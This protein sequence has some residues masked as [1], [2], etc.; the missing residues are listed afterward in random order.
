MRIILVF[1]FSILLI[2]LQLTLA[3]RLAVFGVTPNL[4]L[5]AVLSWAVWRQENK[6][7]WLILIPILI[8]DLLAGRPFGLVA[9]SLC[10]VFF[11]LEELGR[12]LFKQ[13][14]LSAN[15][16][17]ILLGILFFDVS[18]LLLSRVLALG[19]LM[20]PIKLTAFYFYA[21]LPLELM[22][23]GLLS[24]LILWGLNNIKIF[25]NNGPIAKLR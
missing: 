6:K 24:L 9:L 12:I 14:D 15:L 25:K 11:V 16:S 21:V 3:P 19:D 10:L 13:N 4:I 22:L 23:N 1:L 2:A 18:Q 7:G 5:A 17:L 8:F 20:E